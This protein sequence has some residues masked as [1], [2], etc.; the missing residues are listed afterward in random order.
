M[1]RQAPPSILI[2]VVLLVVGCCAI[3]AINVAPLQS[4]LVGQAY[5]A[6]AVPIE[7]FFSNPCLASLANLGRCLGVYPGPTPPITIV[8]V[9]PVP[10]GYFVPQ[11]PRY[12]AP[13]PSSSPTPTRSPLPTLAPNVTP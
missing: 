8:T 11:P 4:A 5:P 7:G 10:P 3:L 6:R 13:Q 9:M 12:P 1:K 2:L